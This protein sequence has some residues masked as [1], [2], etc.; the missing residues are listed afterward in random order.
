M[1]ASIDLNKKIIKPELF[2]C[3][4]NKQIVAKLSEAYNINRNCKLS[5][6]YELD[7]SLPVEIELGHHLVIN[8]NL[9]K[10][11]DKYL[12]KL[13]IG[14]NIEWYI[15]NQITD[16]T[17]DSTDSRTIHAFSLPF[18]LGSKNIKNYKSSPIN[19]EAMPVNCTSAL[20]DILENTLYTINYIDASYDIM[21]RSIEISSST[22]LD[23][24][25]QIAETFGGILIWD[26]ENRKISIYNL[27]NI[28]IN[29]GLRFSTGRLMKGVE[30]VSNADEMVTRLKVFG[31][32]DISINEV[33][34]TG[35]NY[36]EDISYFM[37]LDY[38][39]QGL[40]DSIVAYN[41][42]LESKKGDFTLYLS[43]LTSFQQT[44]TSKSNELATLNTEMNIINGKLDISQTSVNDSNSLLAEV[45][46][47]NKLSPDDKQKVYN[48]W[49][50]MPSEKIV[51]DAQADTYLIVNEKTVYDSVYETLKTYIS[52]ILLDLTVES[53]IDNVVFKSKFADYFTARTNLLN[54]VSTVLLEEKTIKQTEIDNKQLEIDGVNLSITSVKSQITALQSL[55]SI[56]SN[57]T[58]EQIDERNFFIIE[59]EITNSNISIVQ[60][61]YDWGLAEFDKIREPQISVSLDIVN[62]LEVL[63]EQHNWEKLNLG[64]I[65]L[66]Y[67]PKLNIN[68][69]AKIT[70]LNFNYEDSSV[71]LTVSNVAVILSDQ[72]KFVR[73]LYKSMS[74]STEV[75]NSKS[76]WNNIGSVK[77]SVS[78]ILNNS[79]DS[80]KNSI[81][82]AT[83][84]SLT[85]DS[86]GL[87]LRD[88][89]DGNK[90]IRMM[91]STIGLS[92]DG[93][94]TFKTAI[95]P[96]GTVI[97][98]IRFKIIKL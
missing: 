40:I 30:C 33:N 3:K 60:D 93:G 58:Q 51:L 59:K 97:E 7:F 66:I 31:K 28:G 72:E 61:L 53:I 79:W 78:D 18:E 41:A 95:T 23:S 82:G 45:S 62:F 43:Q 42:L 65:C 76:S 35:S 94:N 38:M 20:T 63:E 74:T 39:S 68:V 11:K 96:S 19:G 34:I 56:E 87:T 4:P 70:E 67:Y 10:I 91:N 15:I 89:T 32:D 73:N 80:A 54:K 9:S 90:F 86:R 37:N 83:N 1:L 46:S 6:I 98:H 69:K 71:S 44:L 88:V 47:D 14:T 50:L 2:L 25:N 36:T 27:D 77:N 26:T 21:Y 12:I 55:I 57:F 64:D 5:S 48:I 16:S 17:N 75:S 81:I 22:V 13:V 8:P 84:Q 92:Q 49:K 85:I 24:I 29:K 52:P